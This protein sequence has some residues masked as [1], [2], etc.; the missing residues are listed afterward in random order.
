MPVP[1]ARPIQ[2]QRRRL[3]L[4]HRTAQRLHARIRPWHPKTLKV[5]ETFRVW[6]GRLLILAAL[7]LAACSP[8]VAVADPAPSAQAAVTPLPSPAISPTPL[9][10]VSPAAPTPAA[11]GRPPTLTPA[12]TP[13]ALLATATT[14]P[15]IELLFTGDINPG[16]CVYA[17]AKAAGDMTLPYQG[18]A[19]L[20]QGA[21]LT[22][23]SLDGAISDY[24]PPPPCVETHR[25]LLGPPEVA[26]GLQFAGY[27][28]ITVATNH[29][30]DCGLVRG[31]TNESLLDTLANL[32]AVG[33]APAGGGLNLAEAMA[34]AILTVEGVRFAFL[35]ITAVNTPLWAGP[36]SPGVGAFRAADYVEAIHRAREQADVVIVLPHWGREFSAGITYQQRD[37]AREMVAAGATLVVGNH[38]HRVQGVETFPNG[39]A[40][41]YA[42]GNFVF[43]MTWSDGTL[44]TIQGILLRARFRGAELEGVD[45]LPIHIYD[46]FQ[47]RLADTA[48]AEQI[49]ADVA[50][51]MASAPP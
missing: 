10:A 4:L 3:A 44:F 43:D 25:N 2:S 30:K 36:D 27:D 17:R 6:L 7:V 1:G 50:A 41:A 15:A 45:L 35:G 21:D 51:S 19:P 32:R 24:N 29:A 40:A 22:I 47:P 5:R 18:L 34:P 11:T 33:I 39:A 13:T 23:G 16:R 12:A 37:A 28:V 14:A 38:P 9:P 26:V 20:L 48:E 8:A 31:C 49:L 46:D 42:L